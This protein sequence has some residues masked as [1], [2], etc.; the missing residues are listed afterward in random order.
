M[1]NLIDAEILK[2]TE[3]PS[4]S[5]KINSREQNLMNNISMINKSKL[6]NKNQSDNH[7]NVKVGKDL[8][9][10]KR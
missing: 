5:N 1:R 10:A 9:K 3:S 2:K 7:L 8:L 6:S 4:I